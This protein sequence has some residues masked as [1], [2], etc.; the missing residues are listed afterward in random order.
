[1]EFAW[2]LGDG[3]YIPIDSKFT[4]L[5]SLISAFNSAEEDVKLEIKKRIQ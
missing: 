1:M 4:S 2:D 3:K 5:F